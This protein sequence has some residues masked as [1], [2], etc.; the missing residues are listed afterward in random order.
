MQDVDATCCV[1]VYRGQGKHGLL[2]P[3]ALY[4]CIGHA[5]HDVV[6]R[7]AFKAVKLEK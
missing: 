5:K 2:P 1:T 6:I 7:V 3:A 4:V